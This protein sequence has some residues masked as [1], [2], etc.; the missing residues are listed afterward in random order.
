VQTLRRVRDLLV[1]HR[2]QDRF[3]IRLVGGARNPVELAFP[4][5]TT[6]YCPE[7]TQKLAA[8]VGAGAVQM[9]EGGV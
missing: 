9:E 1:D 5:E 3:V 8:I 4:S 2:G 6:R 7:L